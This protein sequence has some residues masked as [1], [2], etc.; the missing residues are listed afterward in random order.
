MRRWRRW[1]RTRREEEGHVQSSSPHDV[2]TRKVVLSL[3][4]QPTVVH[5]VVVSLR[6][7]LHLTVTTTVQARAHRQRDRRG[8][9]HPPWK[10]Q[11]SPASPAAKH[12]RQDRGCPPNAKV[13]A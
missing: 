8:L 9:S 6:Q 12:C 13:H 1:R 7:H 10:R 3:G 2:G 11:P 4:I 5:R